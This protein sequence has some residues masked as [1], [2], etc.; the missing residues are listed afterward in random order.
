PFGPSGPR[1]P[2]PLIPSGAG[3]SGLPDAAGP[4]TRTPQDG[5]GS[6]ESTGT[7][8]ASGPR[9][10]TGLFVNPSSAGATGG[11]V[12]RSAWPS[13]TIG[14]NWSSGSS[15]SSAGRRGGSSGRASAAAAGPA[16]GD[17]SATITNSGAR[18]ATGAGTPL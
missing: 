11:F 17:S 5:G 4:V 1:G 6:G 18:A 16:A 3:S 8:G 2:P 14:V 9:P 15:Q 7:S 12:P 10:T 13:N